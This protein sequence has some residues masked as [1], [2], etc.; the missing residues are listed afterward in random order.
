MRLNIR[1]SILVPA[2][3]SA[4]ILSDGLLGDNYI[5]IEPGGSDAMLEPGAAITRTQDPVNIADLL[6]RFAF[7]S[8]EE[9]DGAL[10]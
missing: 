2:D 10:E 5:S 6:G 8:A 4:R 1:E 7:G 9:G 3:S